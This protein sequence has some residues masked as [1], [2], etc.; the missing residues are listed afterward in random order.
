MP[1]RFRAAHFTVLVQA[2]TNINVSYTSLRNGKGSRQQQ[3]KRLTF[4]TIPVGN[5][6]E[7]SD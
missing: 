5:V 3:D 1:Y 6:I 4:F 7:L 2:N